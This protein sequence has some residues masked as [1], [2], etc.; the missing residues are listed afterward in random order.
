METDALIREKIDT[1]EDDT[2][3]E[4]EDVPSKDE[5]KSFDSAVLY[6]EGQS[7]ASERIWNWNYWQSHFD[8]STETILRRLKKAMHPKESAEFFLNEKPD[9]YTPLWISITLVFCLS[10]SCTLYPIL[11]GQTHADP[12]VTT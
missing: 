4:M 2:F 8:V 3:I 9:F 7:D 1:L 12:T 10:L 5:V 11:G 6:P